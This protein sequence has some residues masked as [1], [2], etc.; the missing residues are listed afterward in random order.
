METFQGDFI[1][2]T[3]DLSSDEVIAKFGL[4]TPK[5]GFRTKYGYTNAGFV[6]AGKVIEKIAEKTWGD[7]LQTKIFTPLDMNRT[8]AYSDF[9]KPRK[10]C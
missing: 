5:Y 8:I 7:F 2:W 3:S 9:K 4:L 6:I 1:Y 10:H